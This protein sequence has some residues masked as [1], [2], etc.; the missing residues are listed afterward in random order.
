L[1]FSFFREKF[2]WGTEKNETPGAASGERKCCD[3]VCATV[4][5]AMPGNQGFFV[6]GVGVLLAL[7]LDQC[8]PVVGSSINETAAAYQVKTFFCFCENWF[9][10][11]SSKEDQ[12]F[13]PIF[14]FQSH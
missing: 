8:P 6:V 1:P 11:A 13:V 7:T 4:L 9:F 3:G 2:F 10:W 5:E 14:F 12:I